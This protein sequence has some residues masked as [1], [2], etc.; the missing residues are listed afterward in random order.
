MSSWQPS[1]SIV[2]GGAPTKVQKIKCI[3]LGGA[4][5]GKTSILRKYFHGIFDPARRATVGSDFFSKRMPDPT[6]PALSVN[7]ECLDEIHEDEKK[8]SPQWNILTPGCPQGMLSMQVW[9]TP[10]RE[11]F[12]ASEKKP[13]Y[14]AAFSDKFFKNADAALLVY[15][16]TSSTSFTHVLKWYEDLMAR[17][18][19]L[20]ESGERTRPFPVLIVANKLDILLQRDTHPSRQQ[21]AVPQRD[22]MGMSGKRFRGKDSRYEYTASALPETAESSN[23]LTTAT[24]ISS[25]QAQ[26]HR[27]EL[28]TYMG[29]GNQTDYLQAVLNNDVQIGSY[30]E[31]LLSTEDSSHPDIDMVRLWC[32]R[33]GL[34]HMEVSALDGTGIDELMNTMTKMAMEAAKAPA[35]RL[36]AL[37]DSFTHQNDELD[38][39]RRYGSNGESCFTLP[40]R[41]CCNHWARKSAAW[42]RDD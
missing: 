29:T 17:I 42:E 35:T 4:N 14:T 28:S 5:A 33:N 34:Q 1:G 13:M 20:E 3:V 6:A 2:G 7:E 31:S 10:G 32:M 41:M 37:E 36:S 12:A 15:D 23:S 19:R 26:R 22:V 30:L 38:L 9:D 21:A 24:S 8:D 18:R 39:H 25:K 40:F 27:H 16:I 11:R